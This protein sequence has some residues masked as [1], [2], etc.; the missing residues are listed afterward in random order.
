MDVPRAH[1][2]PPSGCDV[3][4]S[5]AD[6]PYRG[7]RCTEVGDVGPGEGGDERRRPGHDRDGSEHACTR[8]RSPHACLSLDVPAGRRS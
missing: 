4:E 8:Y 1:R 5:F 3:G 6:L 2:D 7:A